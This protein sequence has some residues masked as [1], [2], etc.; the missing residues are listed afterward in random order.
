MPYKNSSSESFCGYLYACRRN[1]L[2]A[3]F[4]YSGPLQYLVARFEIPEL[5]LKTSPRKNRQLNYFEKKQLEFIHRKL[6]DISKPMF[7]ISL[8]VLGQ[9]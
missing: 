3:C 9:F 2:L 6:T 7:L 8:Q 1:L 4:I 5:H